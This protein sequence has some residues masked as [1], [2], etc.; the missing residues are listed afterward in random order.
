MAST[1]FAVLEATAVAHPDLPAL[2]EKRDSS[3]QTITWEGYRQKAL[4]VARSFIRLGLKPGQKMAILSANCPRW[5]FADLGAIAAGGVPTSIYTTST[6]EQ[7]QYIAGHCEAGVLVLEDASR[8]ASFDRA[9]LPRLRGVVLMR[10]ESDEPGVHSWRQ[11]LAAGDEVPEGVVRNR[12]DRQQPDDLATLIYT[13]GTTG[14]PKG[15]MLSHQN[16]TW[17]GERV[18]AAFRVG[19]GDLVVSYL[20]LSH[21]AEQVVSLYSPMAVG[22]CTWFAESLDALGAN[23]REARPYMFFGVLWVWEKL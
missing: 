13:S 8:L 5:F 6:T 12:L 17:I 20:P 21:I 16:I 19:T 7:C 22:A 3:W 1:V 23:L 14:P 9:A 15:V 10:G 2:R 18:A 11:L 4:A